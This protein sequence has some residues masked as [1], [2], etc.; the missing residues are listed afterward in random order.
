MK[1]VPL[2]KLI[3]EKKEKPK[4]GTRSF[5]VLPLKGK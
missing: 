3:K 1:K 2:E 4:K 5:K